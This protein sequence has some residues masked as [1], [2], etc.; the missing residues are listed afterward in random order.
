MIKAPK[1]CLI[2]GASFSGGHTDAGMPMEVGKR[3]FY[4]CGARVSVH[5]MSDIGA[6][7]LNIKNCSRDAQGL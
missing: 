3:V 2:C 1:T 6:Y 7:S 4:D 5:S